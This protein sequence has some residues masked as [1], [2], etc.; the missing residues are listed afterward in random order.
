MLEIQS[1]SAGYGGPP[2]LHGISLVLRPGEIVA[3]VGSNGAGS[4]T[5]PPGVASVTIEAW[6]GG[7]AGGSGTLGGGGGGA[8]YCK[9]TYAVAAGTPLTVIVGSGGGLPGGGGGLIARLGGYEAG[10]FALVEQRAVVFGLE[11]LVGDAGALLRRA[12][13]RRSGN[14]TVGTGS[15][16]GPGTRRRGGVAARWRRR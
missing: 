3:V 2:V 8:S 5:V 12:G 9:A 10:Q 7:G 4:C 6:G 1:L 14:S 16:C 13:S 11:H 15:G